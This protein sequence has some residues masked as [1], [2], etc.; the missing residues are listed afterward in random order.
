MLSAHCLVKLLQAPESWNDFIADGRA[1]V[2][3][4]RNWQTSV[5]RYPAV[6]AAALGRAQ[7]AA[8]KT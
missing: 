7:E 4:E 8:G 1:Y 3:G 5:A 6:Y 2:E